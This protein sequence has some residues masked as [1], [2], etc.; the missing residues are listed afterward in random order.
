MR[1]PHHIRIALVALCAVLALT[2]VAAA[3]TFP[4]LSGRVVDE[5]GILNQTTRAT[6]TAR[7]AAVESQTTNQIVVATVTSLQGTEI[8]TYAN[9]L[10]RA[11]RLGQAA[12][13]NG[14]LLLV[15][16]SE[17]KVR[18]EVGYGLE[19]TL[20]DAVAKLIIGQSI[21]PCG[22]PP[23]TRSPPLSRTAVPPTASSLAEYFP[24]APGE[25]RPEELPDKLVE[26]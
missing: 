22:S 5:A 12:K 11:W 23:S 7:L 13:N 8:E 20:T 14:V 26:I 10:F 6:L 21:V 9:G 2:A 17:R 16:P 1:A 3:Q 25:V 19:G 18:I 15:A 24:R 4:T